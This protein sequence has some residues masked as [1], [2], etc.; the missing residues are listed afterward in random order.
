MSSE[1][2]SAPAIGP[3]TRGI[4]VLMP[5]WLGDIVMATAA[6]HRLRRTATE[7]RITALVPPGMDSVLAGSEAVDAVVAIDGKGAIGPFRTAAAIRRTAAEAVILLPNSP[8]SAIAAALSGR[9]I[10][11][12]TPRGGRGGLLSHRVPPP[13][14]AA[15]GAPV[16]A[17]VQYDR[18]IA[19]ATAQPPWSLEGPDAP[20]LRP[21]LVALESDRGAARAVLGSFADQPTLVLV[22]GGNRP[23]KRWPAERFAAVA[24]SLRETHGLMPVVTGSPGERDL[25]AAIAAAIGPPVVDAAAAGGGLSA[26]KGLI[27]T[28]RLVLSNDTGPRHLAAGLGTPAVALFGPTDHRWTSL[29]GVPETTLLAEPFLPETLVA[30][31]HAALCRI[32]RIPVSDVLH[33]AAGRLEAAASPAAGPPTPPAPGSTA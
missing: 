19:F 29:P 31:R 24:R 5:T 13:P 7:A 16:P 23:T 20:R 32:D 9:R 26:V 28:A 6:L 11:I 1:R 4:A 33:A 14:R 15:A 27:A 2:P 22:P 30:D 3:R 17:V 21:T 12:G 18:I 10:R 25:C 8:R